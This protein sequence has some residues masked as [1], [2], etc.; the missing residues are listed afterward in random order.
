MRNQGVAN[1]WLIENTM[2]LCI[3]FWIGEILSQYHKK[4]L[5]K[6]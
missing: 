5:E 2:C 1:V 3:F 4:L 6:K